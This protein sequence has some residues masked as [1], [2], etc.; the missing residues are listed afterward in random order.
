MSKVILKS[1]IFLAFISCSKEANDQLPPK[2]I[3]FIKDFNNE[4]QERYNLVSNSYG[5]DFNKS[6]KLVVINYSSEYLLDK[7]KAVFLVQRISDD[8]LFYLN[9]SLDLN[10]F[11]IPNP[12]TRNQ[13][14][15]DIE[16]NDPETKGP[17][18][19]PFVAKITMKQGHLTLFVY[20]PET[21]KLAHA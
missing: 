17:V 16:F 3:V 13:M 6:V 19:P 12:F 8:F 7:T 11:L 21:N 4:I 5:G 15:I 9:G 10:P 20:D 2:M 1:F 14:D 18:S